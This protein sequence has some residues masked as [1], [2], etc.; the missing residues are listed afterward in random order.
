MSRRPPY[1]LI[2]DVG[3]VALVVFVIL[4]FRFFPGEVPAWAFSL[5]YGVAALVLIGVVTELYFFWRD[6]RAGVLFPMR[7]ASLFILLLCIVGLPLYLA[8]LAATGQPPGASTLLIVPVM[9]TFATRN[10]FRVRIDSLSVRAKTGFRAPIEVPLFRVE[11]VAVSD[12]RLIITSDTGRP[13]HLLRA[14]FFPSHW[15]AIV[16]KLR[17]LST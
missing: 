12:D 2:A 10:L 14:F 9:L 1:Q 4:A 15:A 13:I 5:A 3:S 16:E 8:Y 17:H 6:Y 7:N 11:D